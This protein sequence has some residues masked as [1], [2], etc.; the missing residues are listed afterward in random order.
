MDARSD[1]DG[2]RSDGEHRSTL[3]WMGEGVNQCHR[4]RRRTVSHYSF[5]DGRGCYPVPQR[6]NARRSANTAKTRSEVPPMAVRPRKAKDVLDSGDCE[7]YNEW[8]EESS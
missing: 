1:H 2:D 6:T 5:Q 7:M 8:R 4:V 3:S